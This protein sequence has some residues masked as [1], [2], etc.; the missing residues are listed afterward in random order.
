MQR[1]VDGKDELIQTY[2]CV[3]T[4]QA[5]FPKVLNYEPF[6]SYNV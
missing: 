4:H 2:I 5:I 6:S 3:Y 1:R